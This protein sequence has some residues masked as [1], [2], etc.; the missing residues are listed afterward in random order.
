MN[1]AKDLH[2]FARIC[3]MM[4]RRGRIGCDPFQDG[5]GDL[6]GSSGFLGRSLYDEA[7][8][9]G[10]SWSMEMLPAYSGAFGRFFHFPSRGA[11]LRDRTLQ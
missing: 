10:R 5:A 2:R 7:T 1:G 9:Y 6:A 8:L 11:S 4:G 3:G